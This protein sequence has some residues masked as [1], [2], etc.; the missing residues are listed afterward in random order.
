MAAGTPKPV[1]RQPARQVNVRVEPRVYEALEAVARRERRS[2]SQLSRQLLESGLR[3]RLGDTTAGEEVS[4]HD[5]ASLARDGGGFDW[6]DE[7]PDLY[8]EDSGEPM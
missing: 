5:I 7:E 8:D 2:I 4:S 1:R 6:L 3:D